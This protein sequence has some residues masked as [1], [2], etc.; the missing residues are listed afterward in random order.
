MWK[1][2]AIIGAV[3]AAILGSG[4]VALAAS[5]G[6]GNQA[7]AGR[8]AVGEGFMAGHRHHGI[9]HMAKNLEH[10]EFVSREDGKNVTHDVI[11]G[12]VTAVSATSISVKATD[13]FS[14][15]FTVNGDTRVRARDGDKAAD[16]ITDIR[17][18]DTVFASG[19][20]DGSTVTAKHVV[21]AKD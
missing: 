20:K 11:H 9:A 13:G 14:L 1:K 2:V 18:G 19:V 6:G 15:T 21:K 16:K 10:G 4:A 5:G 12:E 17:A 7:G 3:S 8:T